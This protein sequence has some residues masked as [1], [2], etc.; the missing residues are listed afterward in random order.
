MDRDSTARTARHRQLLL[1]ALAIAWLV[2]GTIFIV[3]LEAR[4]YGPGEDRSAFALRLGVLILQL[5]IAVSSTVLLLWTRHQRSAERL[6]RQHA[7]E[8]RQLFHDGT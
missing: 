4:E 6:A 8:F 3:Q 7:E 2:G 5:L 1:A